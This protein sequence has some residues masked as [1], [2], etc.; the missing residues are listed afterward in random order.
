MILPRQRR[1]GKPARSRRGT[2][3]L[4]HATPA[5]NLPSIRRSGLLCSFSQGRMPVVW[6]HA[7]SKTFWAMVHTVERHSGR[8]EQVVVLEV[9][10]P[11]RWLR[12]SR[13]G[14]WYCRH[15]IAAERIRRAWRFA[16]LSTSPVSD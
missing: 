2:V 5:R 9:E 4:R 6:L 3:T 12:R 11:R 10:V 7:A 1:A 16:E 13:R 15:D 14:L 8:I